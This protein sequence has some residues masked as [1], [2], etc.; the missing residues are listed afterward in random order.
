[1]AIVLN[2]PSETTHSE[3]QQGE[4]TPINLTWELLQFLIKRNKQ[5]A[6]HLQLTHFKNIRCKDNNNKSC[7]IP[8]YKTPENRDDLNDVE[9]SNLLIHTINYKYVTINYYMRHL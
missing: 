5:D 1:M 8:I 3:Q 9:Q 2:Q 4:T 7:I 6:T